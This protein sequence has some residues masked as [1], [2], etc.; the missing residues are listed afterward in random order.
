MLGFNAPPPGIITHTSER[1]PVSF[2][3]IYF[4]LFYA[5]LT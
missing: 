4:P 2:L 1:L 5:R 3:T